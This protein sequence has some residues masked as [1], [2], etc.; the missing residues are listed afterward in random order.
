MPLASFIY[1]YGFKWGYSR[2]KNIFH[3]TYM[4]IKDIKYV[5]GY[6]LNKCG[7]L[8]GLKPQP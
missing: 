5:W 6:A 8:W 2:S 3:D 1:V 4:G 7:V